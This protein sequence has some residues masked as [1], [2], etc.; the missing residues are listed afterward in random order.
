MK[1]S[2]LMEEQIIGILKVHE[3]GGSVT[4]L[5]RKHGASVYKWK[6]KFDGM[7]MSNVMRRP[8]FRTARRVALQGKQAA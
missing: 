5:C 6:A 2:R 3:A 1:R 7:D 8:D 4:D